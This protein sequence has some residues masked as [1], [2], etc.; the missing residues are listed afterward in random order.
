MITPSV[1]NFLKIFNFYKLNPAKTV[2]EKSEET[3]LYGNSVQK[4]FESRF[5]VKAGKVE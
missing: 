3:K 2:R 4:F 5:T 1:E